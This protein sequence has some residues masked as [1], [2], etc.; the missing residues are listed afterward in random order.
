MRYNRMTIFLWE[1]ESMEMDALTKMWISFV[2]IGLF[3]LS[4]VVITL[5]RNKLKG[6]LR[7]LLSAVAFLML[8]VGFV[9]S[10]IAIA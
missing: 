2:G 9:C 4:A 1:L 10:L 3:G 5:A 6:V 7:F 8:V